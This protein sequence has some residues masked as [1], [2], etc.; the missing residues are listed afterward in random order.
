MA[1]PIAAWKLQQERLGQKEKP[2]SELRALNAKWAFVFD[3]FDENQDGEMTQE[4]TQKAFANLLGAGPCPKRILEAAIKKIAGEK[5]KD[6][7][8]FRMFCDLTKS[9]TQTMNDRPKWQEEEEEEEEKEQARKARE[10]RQKRNSAE[11]DVFALLGIKKSKDVELAEAKKQEAVAAAQARARARFQAAGQSVIKKAMN[12]KALSALKEGGGGGG[13]ASTGALG[14]LA[15]KKDSGAS[16]SGG[17]I[18][19]RGGSF[20]NL[21][22]RA[23]MG[24]AP[25]SPTTKM[26]SSWKRFEEASSLS[27]LER[28]SRGARRRQ[29]IDLP[30]DLPQMRLGGSRAGCMS[31]RFSGC[32]KYLAGGFYD[33]GL[34]IYDLD[35]TSFAHCLNLPRAM[36]GTLGPKE[37]NDDDGAPLP[38]IDPVKAAS[39]AAITNVRWSPARGE[40]GAAIVACTDTSGVVALWNIPRSGQPHC[41]VQHTG[42]NAKELS[43][44]A[45]NEDGD[46]IMVGGQDRVVRIYDVKTRMG[47]A[48]L[49]IARFKD[50]TGAKESA[51]LV[52]GSRVAREG[53]VG[54]HSSKILSICPDW[55]SP[56]V[57]YTLG[58]DRKI[59]A[60]DTRVGVEP[61]A[62]FSA[63]EACGDCMDISRDGNQLMIGSHRSASPF[64]L[65]DTR[66]AG[67]RA[68]TAD[69]GAARAG[70][71]ESGASQRRGSVVEGTKN[72]ASYEWAGNEAPFADG[73]RPTSC[74]VMSTAWDN[75]DNKLI[76][77]A[78]E[79]E[80]LARIYERGDSKDDPWRVVSTFYGDKHAFWSSA[81][82]GDGRMAAFGSA[83]G[84]VLLV[85]VEHR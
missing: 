79:N 59:L 33:G 39:T 73:A 52:L 70:S 40:K 13:T 44:L 71:K 6:S 34:R 22:K 17:P 72:V 7:F 14:L 76:V 27:A 50:E 26:R 77:A 23:T 19:R 74:L 29:T 41:L 2:I 10:E 82:A 60:W 15:A 80:N 62:M 61:M 5:G 56:G 69:A 38:E 36:G 63:A 42:P 85:D 4:E 8:D 45:F 21:N 30:S 24:A 31:L 47:K 53:T 75:W 35:S 64:L 68:G 37:Q 66:L 58:M 54:G 57:L 48:S 32:G 11:Q 67:S 25:V 28:S 18:V 12:L 65:Y 1:D 43:A 55:K 51:M 3:K 20:A 49:E 9:V 84:G 16:G 78:G 46:K 81:I 83:D